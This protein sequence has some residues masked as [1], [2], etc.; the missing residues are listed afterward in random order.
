MNS[1][2]EYKHMWEDFGRSKAEVYIYLKC[3]PI[4]GTGFK[5]YL[6]EKSMMA[7]LALKNDDIF[8]D[9]GCASGRHVFMASLFCQK[10]V[11]V[12]IVSSFVEKAYSHAHENS[13]KNVEFH[14]SSAENLPFDDH[15]FGKILCAETLEHVL[16]PQRTL[17]EIRRVLRPGGLAVITVPNKN[18]GGTLYGSIKRLLNKKRFEP[19]RAFSISE[20]EHHGDAHLREFDL[21]SLMNLLNRE[22]FVVDKVRGVSFI[23]FPFADKVANKLN[24]IA[25]FRFSMLMLEGI[26]GSKAMMA[27]WGKHLIVACRRS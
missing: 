24:S 3:D 13:I 4:Y 27:R 9:V 12:D 17:K 14:T 15:T 7:L 19:L 25:L 26:V 11:G 6:R 5:K 16:E 10:A 22:G 18:G 2:G 8:L 1:A 20:I 21:K 23:D